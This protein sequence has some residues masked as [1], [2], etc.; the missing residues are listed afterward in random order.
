ADRA[1]RLRLLRLGRAEGVPPSVEA[2]AGRRSRELRR[3][4]PGRHLRRADASHGLDLGQDLVGPL[5]ALEREPARPLPRPLPLLLRVLHAA[6]LRRGRP[7]PR[8]PLRGLR[9]LRR[10]TDSRQLSR[11]PLGPALHSPV[12][13]LIARATCT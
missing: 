9:P 5:V 3:D 13:L 7:G 10:R 8:E 2:P 12:S 11:D 6:V 4:P 1:D